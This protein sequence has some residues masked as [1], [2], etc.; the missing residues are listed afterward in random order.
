MRLFFCGSRKIF[1]QQ[2]SLGKKVLHKIVAA[3]HRLK[4]DSLLT[5]VSVQHTMRSIKLI[6][7]GANPARVVSVHQ[8]ENFFSLPGG[9]GHATNSPRR[10]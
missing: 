10:R 1:V 3:M 8:L 5:M 4:W 9:P 6:R 7:F 2:N